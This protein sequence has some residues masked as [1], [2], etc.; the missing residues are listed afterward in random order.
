MFWCNLITSIFQWQYR[1][2][3]TEC[4]TGTYGYFCE[5][6][7]SNCLYDHCD[8]VTGQCIKGCKSNWF[9][10]KCDRPCR[11]CTQCKKGF[12]FHTSRQCLKCPLNCSSCTSESW[13]T[14]CLPTFTGKQCDNR[15]SEHCIDGKC[16]IFTRSCNR[17]CNNQKYG[18][19]CYRECPKQCLLCFAWNNCTI[20][21]PGFFGR[22]CNQKCPVNCF[23]CS[24]VE[25]CYTCKEGYFGKRCGKICPSQTVGGPCGNTTCIDAG[26]CSG[27]CKTG[28][29]GKYCNMTCSTNG[30]CVE[31]D[32]IS[33]SCTQC[34]DG[35]Y[36]EN[37]S[38]DCE[39][40]VQSACNRDGIC[41]SGCIP[42]FYGRM[43]KMK[44]QGN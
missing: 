12:Y 8:D 28:W 32:Q 36:G 16:N 1:I 4:S 34:V 9:G 30:N 42:G 2:F 19:G 39:N 20:C 22:Y 25:N 41:M 35:R 33:G 26:I 3:S 11:N 6:H 38:L 23:N 21:K 24:S 17:G 13:C 7:C 18:V 44:S 15:C 43:C 37:C 27:G 14:E 5:K 10:E 40:C 31:C 29:Y